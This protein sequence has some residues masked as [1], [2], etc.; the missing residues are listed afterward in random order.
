[1][2]DDDVVTYALNGLSE[3]FQNLAMLIAH[4]DPF[5]NLAT[6]RS[7]VMTEELRMRSKT[8]LPN[9]NN[10]LSAPQVLLAQA[11]ATRGNDG[12]TP[13]DRDSRNNNK[14]E[15]CRNYGRGF[16]RWGQECRYIHD[17]S[18]GNQR[19]T[20]SS[21]NTRMNQNSMHTGGNRGLDMASQQ[22]LLSILQAQTTL[23]AQFGLNPSNTRTVNNFRP[24]NNGILGSRPGN[25][26][27]LPQAQHQGNFGLTPQQQQA[28]L[29]NIGQ[30]TNSNPS[31]QETLLPQ[32]FNTMTIQD[33]TDANWNM[34]TVKNK[35]TVEFDEFGFSVKDFWTRQILLRCDSTGDL[36]P[37]TTPTL[38]QAYLVSQPSLSLPDVMPCIVSWQARELLCSYLKTIVKQPFDIVHS[39]L[40]TSPLSSVTAKKFS[41]TDLG[42]LNYFLGIFVT[43]NS[44]GMF[45]SQQK[46]ATGILECAGMLTCNPCCTPVDTDSKIAV[47]GDPILDPTL[48][49]SLAGALQYL[50]FTRPDMSYAVQQVCLFM[51]DPQE[52]HFSALKWILRYVRGSLDFG[53]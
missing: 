32:A 45:L 10:T 16:C 38:P 19:P 47:D 6:V 17:S 24:S 13:R 42:P 26:S 30:V 20:T 46:Y 29:A 4:K 53:L 33:P 8:T 23:L 3:K 49:R 7:M 18:R 14:T 21:G 36:Y 34:D 52:P 37:V 25:N 51:H 48:Y 44:S 5:P 27:G 9:D 11:S 2:S 43:R 39:D 35:C 31:G 41:M 40:W 15:V 28:F 22:Q 12:R 50:T 1:M